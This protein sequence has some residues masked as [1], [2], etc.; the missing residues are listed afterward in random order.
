MNSESRI[1]SDFYYEK[2]YIGFPGIIWYGICNE[3][4]FLSG[5]SQL[6]HITATVLEMT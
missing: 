1:P 5:A 3:R 6:L 4:I 2:S